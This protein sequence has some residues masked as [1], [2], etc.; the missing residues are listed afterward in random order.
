V[1]VRVRR[2]PPEARIVARVSPRAAS[3]IVRELIAHAIAATPRG[4]A[5]AVTANARENDGLGARI[6]V[7][8]AGTILPAGARRPLLSLE[9]EPGTFGRPSSVAL[10]VAAEIALA[11]GALLEIADAPLEEGRGGGVRVSVTFPR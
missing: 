11:Q 3:A 8:D 2:E 4:S 5:V 10:F 1:E 7:D 9:V 6:V